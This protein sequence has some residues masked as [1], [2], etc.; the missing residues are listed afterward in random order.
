MAQQNPR[1]KTTVM[2]ILMMIVVVSVWAAMALDSERA[3]AQPARQIGR[4]HD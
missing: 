3:I 2:L 4:A 1:A